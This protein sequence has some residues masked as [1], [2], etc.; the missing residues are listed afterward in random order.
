M[1]RFRDTKYLITEDGK[2]WSEYSNKFLAQSKNDGYPFV[3]ISGYNTMK[4]HRLVAEVY[5]ENPNNY[6]CINHINNNRSDNR[7][8]NLEWCTNQMN[9]IH[10]VT[11]KRHARG[12][13]HGNVK[14]TESDVK[15]IIRL[16]ELGK[17]QVDI[18][19]VFGLNPRSIY[20]IVNK[21]TW[22]HIHND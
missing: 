1:K 15:E 11:Q 3:H 10:S 22:K 16:Y 4:V 7:V 14:L 6:E 8:E 9:K 12:V 17:K 21:I 5:L 20:A 19:N 13:S 18:A 2:V